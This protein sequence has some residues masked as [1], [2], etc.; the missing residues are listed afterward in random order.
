MIFAS[1]GISWIEEKSMLV[2]VAAI[3]SYCKLM[4]VRDA[5]ILPSRRHG[6]QVA[7]SMLLT[8]KYPIEHAATLPEINSFIG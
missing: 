1:D 5:A 6:K 3:S 7:V 2:I 8:G 4:L